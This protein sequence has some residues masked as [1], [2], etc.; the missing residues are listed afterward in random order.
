MMSVVALPLL[1]L[2][3]LS[4]YSR[5]VDL[6]FYLDTVEVIKSWGYPVEVHTATTSD[7]FLLDLHRIPHGK[8]VARADNSSRPVVFLQ[9][10]FL[11]SS[12]DWVA[13]LPHQSAGF[14]FADAGFDV[15]MGNFRGN[16]YSRKH[17]SLNPNDDQEFWD[18][19]WDQIAEFDLPAMIKKTLEVS[20]QPSVYYVGHSL[21]TLTMFSKL[22]SDPSFSRYI[23]RY[24]ALA[25]VA[26]VQHIR[27]VFSFLGRLF[28]SDFQE[29]IVKY[30]CGLFETL[31]ELCSDIIILFVG[32]TTEHWNQTRVP[33]YLAHTPAGSSSNLLAHFD[34]MFSYGGMPAFDMGEERN[35]KKYGQKL[36]P[37]YNLTS[38]RDVPIYLFWSEDDWISTKQDL[39]ET[40][41]AQLDPQIVQASYRIP[42]YNHLHFIWGTNA[43]EKI[44]NRVVG[45]ITRNDN[46]EYEA[47]L[48][49]RS[50]LQLTRQ[51]G[52]HVGLILVCILY[53]YAGA[54]FFMHYE[55]PEED[56]IHR[57]V[58]KKFG[59]LKENF[60][61]EAGRVRKEDVPNTRVNESV[62]R[63]IDDYS[64]HMLKLFTNPVAANMFDCLF[65]YNSNY[66][67]LWTT[68]S[69]LL[70]TATTIIPVGYG[71][72]APLTST[73]RLVLC[74]Y[75]GF[76]IPLALVMMSDVGKFFADVFVKFFNENIT[77]FMVV[78]VFLLVAYSILGGIAISKAVGYP[79]I[80]G[81]YFSTITIF[82]IGYGDISPAIPVYIVIAFIVFGVALVT[83]ASEFAVFRLPELYSDFGLQLTSWPPT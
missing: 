70:F 27:G 31:E 24:F 2:L 7:G 26:T 64:K 49:M 46:I 52:L 1:L 74:V 57:K 5:S 82:T 41:F 83:V 76:G 50:A 34:Q 18:W 20:G 12:F 4:Q 73:G 60:L 28:G 48:P 67:P 80:D 39:K 75:A 38:I 36:P 45:I 55:S 10:G 6:E 63:L 13:N 11:C 47:L 23:K 44:Y 9:H 35:V 21:G 66:T 71:Y 58:S 25:P 78:L 8:G 62:S 17:V 69:S 54:L 15:W 3:L 72:I 79:M 51:G 40:L 68:D 14:V 56:R 16:T 30:T 29:Y 61:R 59:T 65:Y 43:A 33:I 81:I 53:V 42:N 77:A 32:T 37:Q 19:S 22:S